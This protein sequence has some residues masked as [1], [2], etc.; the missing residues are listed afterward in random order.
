MV[1]RMLLRGHKKREREVCYLEHNQNNTFTK[2]GTNI[3]DVKRKNENSGMSYNEVKNSLA[4]KTLDEKTFSEFTEVT[5]EH[6]VK[7]KD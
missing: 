7:K 6:G 5:S 2:S 1:K 3:E 4:G